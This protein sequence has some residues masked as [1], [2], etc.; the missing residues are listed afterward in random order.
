MLCMQALNNVLNSV[1]KWFHHTL[2]E[3]AL[4]RFLEDRPL[5][6]RGLIRSWQLEL[7]ASSKESHSRLVV[8]SHKWCLALDRLVRRSRVRQVINLR[9]NSWPHS[10]LQHL[11]LDYCVLDCYCY[12]C[13]CTT[14]DWGE[15]I[16][17]SETLII[18]D[19]YSVCSLLE[20]PLIMRNY[21]CKNAIG[22][23][24]VYT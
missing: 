10:R 16:L 17:P 9:S 21:T 4:T 22:V 15:P 8:S 13:T 1:W 5:A 7:S 24:P 14:Y 11:R 19:V 2:E 23:L 18:L 20:F 3:L 12:C 6:I